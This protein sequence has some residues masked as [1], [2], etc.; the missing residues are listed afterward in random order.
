MRQ[1]SNFI[2]AR[3]RP[4]PSEGQLGSDQLIF[5]SLPEETPGLLWLA[6]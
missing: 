5:T 6:L 4:I 1:C 3:T 2:P